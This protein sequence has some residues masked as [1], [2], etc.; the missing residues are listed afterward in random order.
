MLSHTQKKSEQIHLN[1]R[2]TNNQQMYK[3]HLIIL[4][5]REMQTLTTTTYHLILVRMAIIK[6]QR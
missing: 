4:A 1:G 5:I 6:N 2:N 3:T